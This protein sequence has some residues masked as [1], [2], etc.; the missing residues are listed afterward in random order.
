M[1]VV[2]CVP[3]NN[4][5]K[6]EE[7]ELV[8]ALALDRKKL[9]KMLRSEAKTRSV[10]FKESLRISMQV[11]IFFHTHL[12]LSRRDSFPCSFLVDD[13]CRDE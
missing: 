11:G 1:S 6:E 3:F 2:R 5:V 9:P 8:R 10:M 4:S 12:P 13:S 7:D